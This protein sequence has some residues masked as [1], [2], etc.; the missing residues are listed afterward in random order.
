MSHSTIERQ[1]TRSFWDT[2]DRARRTWAFMSRYT[3]E[4][5]T[6]KGMDWEGFDSLTEAIVRS[7]EF[8]YSK[9]YKGNNCLIVRRDGDFR[10]NEE[11]LKKVRL[12]PFRKGD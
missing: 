10:T 11:T 6:S 1:R 2:R 5:F 12:I 3:L 4:I 8:E 9:I 7:L